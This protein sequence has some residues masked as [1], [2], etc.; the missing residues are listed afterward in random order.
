MN[1]KIAVLFV[2]ALMCSTS[3]AQPST[4]FLWKHTSGKTMCNPDSPGAGWTKTA[5][6]FEDSNCT[7]KQPQ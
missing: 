3:F 5:G 4:Y 7:I 2:T 6:P 1:R